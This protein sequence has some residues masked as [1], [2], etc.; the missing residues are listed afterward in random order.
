MDTNGVP[1][2]IES[3]T[4]ATLAKASDPNTCTHEY[5]FAQFGNTMN[6]VVYTIAERYY[7]KMCLTESGNATRKDIYP[8][9]SQYRVNAQATA[10]T[11]TRV[12]NQITRE[13]L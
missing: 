13:K 4:A 10:F 2:L 5:Y 12:F 7:Q 1:L 8:G 3:S 9:E 6:V 11:V